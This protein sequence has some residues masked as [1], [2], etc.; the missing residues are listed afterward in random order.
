MRADTVIKGGTVVDGTGAPARVTD[1]ALHG[2]VIAAIGPDLGGRVVVDGA[3]YV[4]CPGFIDIHTHYDAQ[5]FWDPA[6]TP[7]S[8]H[9]VTTVITGNCGFSIAPTRPEHRDLIARTLENVEDMN[10]ATFEA[11]LPWDF[12]TF[13]EY[14]AS[15]RRHGTRLNFG[16]YLGHSA[17][18]LF[19]M[20]YAA[21]ERTASD[22]ELAEMCQVLR[23]GMNAGAMGFSTSFSVS[24]NGA[25]GKPVPSRFADRS[26]FEALLDVMGTVGRGVVAVVAGEQCTHE[27]LYRLQPRVG[28]PF[29]YGALMS[30]PSGDHRRQIDLHRAGWAAGSEVW[31]QVSPRP[32][33]FGFSMA[34]PFPFGPNPAFADLTTRSL[35]ERR[36]AYA[37]EGWRQR[38]GIGAREQVIMGPRW[39]T[40]TVAESRAHA[41]LVGARLSDVAIE[42]GQD[43]LE[44]LLDLALD[45]ADLGLRVHS[46]VCNDDPSEVG[47]ILQEPHCAI[48][49]SD[50]GA[51][52][53]QLCDAPQA[54]DFLGNWVRGRN[55]MSL[56]EGVRRLT[57]AQAA[58]FGLDDRGTLQVG[59]AA[60]VVV[61]DPDTIGPGPTVR[62]R[63]FPGDAERL[64][65]PEPE[66]I[67]SVFVNG[68]RIAGAVE[69]GEIVT[70]A[71]PG[72]IVRPARQHLRAGA[73]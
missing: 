67:H 41:D 13:P 52:L 68:V 54:T 21:Y 16:T 19:V 40:V 12:V 3:G 46:T 37:D 66:G 29:T 6:L 4:V 28:I 7:S 51:H 57:G 60:D 2:G 30:M 53:D 45:E 17:L 9:G 38:A 5:V 70:T 49:I 64:S 56:E 61:F 26:E 33:V 59:Q 8:F 47:R 55:V 11:G 65:A 73:T 14:L 23:E 43:P 35:A 63:D 15:V 25:D 10:P 39:E 1:I 18:R 71:R 34:H 50:A 48:G 20:G 22:E 42:R 36:S 24:H 72:Q 27:D 32:L 31:P 62:L 44:A 69:T 58:L